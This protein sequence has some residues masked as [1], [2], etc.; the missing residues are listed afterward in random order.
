[1]VTV[2]LGL[3]L[4]MK[5]SRL[6]QFLQPGQEF[7][8]EK[9]SHGLSRKE[10]TTFFLTPVPL[11]IK[12]AAGTYHVQMRVVREVGAPCVQDADEPWHSSQM[13]QIPGQFHDRPR[14]GMEK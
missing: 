2:S 3:S 10:E 7:P 11:C 1:M 6:A 8:L 4:I 5:S 12:S 13:R 9:R 14:C